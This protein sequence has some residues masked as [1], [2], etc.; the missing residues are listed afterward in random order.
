ML[1]T[2]WRTMLV[3]W[4]MCVVLAISLPWSR[5]DGTAHWTR[6]QW[7]PFSHLYWHR[8]VLAE[9]AL[10]ILAFAPVGYLC[11]RS[12]WSVKWSPLLMACVVGFVSSFSIETYQLFCLNRVPSVNDVVMNVIGTAC[13]AWLASS[14]DQIVAWCSLRFWGARRGITES[15]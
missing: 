11:V 15:R 8:T 6:V 7:I 3:L 12:V 1:C 4:L 14:I 9:A 13:G 10:N 2:A 5:F